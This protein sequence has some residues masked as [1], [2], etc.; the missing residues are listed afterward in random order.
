MVGAATGLLLASFWIALF[1]LALFNM[2]GSQHPF[3]VNLIGKQSPSKIIFPFILLINP[4]CA[5]FGVL[6]AFLFTII[7]NAS[8][9]NGLASPNLIYTGFVLLVTLM[10]GAPV[11][12]L[13][14][15]LWR[16]HLGALVSFAVSFGWLIP[17]LAI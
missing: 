15:T 4:T 1:C 17:Y 9:G 16:L 6:F 14:R 3:A 2:Y 8:P 13:G 5:G 11:L 10:V 7:E 12:I